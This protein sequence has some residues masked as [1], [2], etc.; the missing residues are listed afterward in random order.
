MLYVQ[1]PVD[2]KGFAFFTIE[3]NDSGKTDDQWL[4]IPALRKTKMIATS[5]RSSRFLGSDFTYADLNRRKIKFY[6]FKILKEMTVNGY[7]TWLIEAI[8]IDEKIIKETGYTKSVFFVIK[9]HFVI[10]RAIH[11]VKKEKKLKYFNVKE[12]K[13]IDGIWVPIELQMRVKK[14]KEFIGSTVIKF[15]NTEFNYPLPKNLFSTHRLDKPPGRK[16]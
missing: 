2:V 10:I 13:L 7:E 4:Y 8:P 5:D 15:F 14:G 1:E 12:L 6:K 16:K 3:Y 11:W 9:K